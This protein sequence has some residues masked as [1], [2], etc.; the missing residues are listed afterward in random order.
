MLF[1]ELLRLLANNLELK[2]AFPSEKIFAGR[3][4]TPLT[5]EDAFPPGDGLGRFRMKICTRPK[6]EMRDQISVR[7]LIEYSEAPVEARFLRQLFQI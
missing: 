1:L 2:N 4:D 3:D 7:R 5:A 6:G